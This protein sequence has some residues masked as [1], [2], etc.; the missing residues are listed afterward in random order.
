[1]NP[2]LPELGRDNSVNA[3]HFVEESPKIKYTITC[4]LELLLHHQKENEG[5]E[6]SEQTRS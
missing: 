3:K 4:A 1:M 6:E 2:L 5:V